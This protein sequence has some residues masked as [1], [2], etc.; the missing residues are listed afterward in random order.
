M[1]IAA[2]HQV[3]RHRGEVLVHPQP[4][5]TLD[6]L[7]PGRAVLAAAADV[8]HHVGAAAGE[9]APADRA[10]VGRGERHLEAAVAG[11]QRRAAAA[12]DEVRDPGAVV[13]GGEVL[14]D[15][16]V[17]GGEERGCPLE[18][19]GRAAVLA[20]DLA[21][22]QRGRL[23]VAARVEEVLV[24]R[25]RVGVEDVRRA[26]LGHPGQWRAGPAVRAGGEHLEPALHVR[27]G[28]DDQVVAGPRVVGQRGVL[29]GLEQ[30]LEVPRAG[31]E[32]VEPRGQQRARRVG[33]AADRPLGPRADQ[34]PLAVRGGL[35]VLGHLD[36]HQAR[37]RAQVL[38]GAVEVGAAVDEVALEALGRVVVGARGHVVRLA[39]EHHGRLAERCA[40]A[41][42]L[43]DA[44]VAGA[45]ERALAEVGADVDVVLVDP[46]HP[47]LRLRQREPVLDERQRLQVELAHHGR[48]GAAPG[49]LDERAP[50][51]GA[52]HRGALPHPVLAL[53]LG[54][55]VD[56]EDQL[57]VRVGPAV[58]LQRRAPPQPARVGR[59][60]PEV[61]E[62]PVAPA[63]VRDAVVGVEDLADPVA[64][65]GEPGRAGQLGDGLR[66]ALPH[67][68]QR[69]VPRDVL[70]P[71]VR[72]VI[73]HDP[74]LPA[75]T[76]NAGGP[77]PASAAA[78]ADRCPTSCRSRCRSG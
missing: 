63:H 70:Q 48:V 15:G 60:L 19:L 76:G 61:V 9:P 49:Q 39:L 74:S 28:G 42:L 51:T 59:V 67:P 71:E 75:V 22:E 25:V 10:A 18:H 40:A 11:E 56:V 21:A 4:L 29:V 24:A 27:Q 77:A 30:H 50:V 44:R 46:A 54:Q 1:V 20:A 32:L 65:L 68:V 55:R 14:L 37:R 66:V 36:A 58:G 2:G 17:A 33:R 26:D 64:Q 41:P 16:Q 72:V 73:A 43:H 69:S 45:G 57:P 31:E 53:R 12:H 6:G 78:R 23:G 8:G 47:A 38:L 13:G 35:G 62:V 34:Q 5:S 52:Q 3:P 7:V